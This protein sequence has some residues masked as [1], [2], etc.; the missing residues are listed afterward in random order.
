MGLPVVLYIP[1]QYFALVSAELFLKC[2][3]ESSYFTLFS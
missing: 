3:L 2:L 1:A